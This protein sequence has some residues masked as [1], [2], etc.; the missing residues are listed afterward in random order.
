MEIFETD[1]EDAKLLKCP[2]TI[3]E[4]DELNH[5]ASFFEYFSPIQTSSF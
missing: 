5:E 3:T 2:E 4:T 1:L